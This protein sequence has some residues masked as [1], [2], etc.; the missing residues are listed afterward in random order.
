[1]SLAV[2]V[3][4]TRPVT[5]APAAGAETATVGGV[6]STVTATP[7]LVVV[8]LEVSRATAVSVCGPFTTPAVFQEIE[9]GDAPVTSVPIFAPSTLNCTPAIATL[10]LAVA[11]RVTVP[12]TRAFAVG[13]VNVTVGGVV[14]LGVVR[15][16]AICM[17]Q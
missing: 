9:N 11:V 6:V 10:S 5:V 17:T 1:M 12:V 15:K 14:S 2:A 8:R 3:I 7:A 16:A 13:A 4:V